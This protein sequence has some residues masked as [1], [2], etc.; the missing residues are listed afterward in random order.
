MIERTKIDIK[1]NKS[2]T[3]FLPYVDLQI[4]FQYLHLLRNSYLSFEEGDE[5]FCVL[6][7]WDGK[8]DFTKYEGELMN[9]V[10]FLDHQDYG[11]FV[12][13][14]FKLTRNMEDA[15]KLFVNGKY[16]LFIDEH[17]KSIETFLNKRG[18]TNVIRIKKILN[19]DG[20]FRKEL[21][22]KL[23]VTIDSNN[24]LSSPP[25]THQE[26]FLNHVDIIKHKI[27]DFK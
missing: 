11:E 5:V 15:R 12:L 2:S 17:K 4:K 6:Y 24:E 25:D 26:T 14:K 13:Y 21:D 19:R 9:H 3:Y 7:Q 18:F 27:E 16:S 8:P 22:D 20:D 23:G 10:L 1:L